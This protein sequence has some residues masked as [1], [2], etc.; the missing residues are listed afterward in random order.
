MRYNFIKFIILAVLMLS[1]GQAQAQD[2]VQSFE[3]INL[4][5][6]TDEGKK[7]WD[8]S[9]DK[10]DMMG[11]TIKLENV[12]ANHFGDQHV[13]LT[14]KTGEIDKSTGAVELKTDVVITTEEGQQLKTESLR[15]EK[16]KDLVST[17]DAVTLT[18]KSMKATGTGLTAQP[19]LKMAQMNKNV[20]VEVQT[21]PDQPLGKVVTVT[22]DGPVEIDQMNNLAVFHG[23]VVAHQDDRILKSDK[24]EIHLDPETKKVEQTVC[25]GNVVIIQGENTTHS[26][27]AV[28]HVATQKLILSGKP[29]LI[30]ITNDEDGI[31]SFR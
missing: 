20:T 23:N 25:L 5:G 1:S 24:M 30:M 31:V 9:G 7:S 2:Q 8:V 16:E 28:F 22:C 15:W 4:E 17:D 12:N 27:K 29:K 26:D 18:D 14:A 13:N 3:G 19:G 6:Y 21:E 10:A 11:D